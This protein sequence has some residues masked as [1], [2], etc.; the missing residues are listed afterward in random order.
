[1]GASIKVQLRG[2]A[3]KKGT[4]ICIISGRG[5]KT[6]GASAHTAPISLAPLQIQKNTICIYRE[7]IQMSHGCFVVFFSQIG[8]KKLVNFSLYVC[9][10]GI[11]DLFMSLGI[12]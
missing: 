8:H 5:K 2:G 7:M 10:L 12:I 11:I 4:L 1:M 6:V 9:L 3:E